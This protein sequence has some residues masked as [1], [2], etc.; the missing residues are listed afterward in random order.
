M[1]SSGVSE[2]PCLVPDFNGKVSS[3]SLFSMMLPLGFSEVA[4]IML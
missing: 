2:Q 1:K 4:L 3:V